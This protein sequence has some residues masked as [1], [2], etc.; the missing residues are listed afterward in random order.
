MTLQFPCN[1]YKCDNIAISSHTSLK[2]AE[3]EVKASGWYME[4]THLCP[5]CTERIFDESAI[6]RN[7]ADISD[8]ARSQ[9][10]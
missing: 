4:D 5:A 10:S 7:S 3:L 8:I 9:D 2:E 6:I 1:A